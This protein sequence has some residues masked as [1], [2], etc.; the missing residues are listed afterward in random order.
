MQVQ[1]AG[2]AER[3][4]PVPPLHPP[5][6]PAAVAAHRAERHGHSTHS[7]AHRSEHPGCALC[8]C[9]SELCGS[10]AAWPALFLPV[11][12]RLCLLCLLLCL[13]PT[14]C[15]CL[16]AQLTLDASRL[17]SAWCAV[18]GAAMPAMPA[19]AVLCAA[20][21]AV[22]A[23]PSMPYAAMP[24]MSDAAVPAM[25]GVA[26]SVDY[27]NSSLLACASWSWVGCRQDSAGNAGVSW[28]WQG[29]CASTAAWM[30]SLWGGRCASTACRLMP[31]QPARL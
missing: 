26:M 30:S 6:R 2:R 17:L 12:V 11:L 15:S 19:A 8:K 24:A 4:I 22:P 21:P 29:G 31:W 5:V 13:L 18:P 16:I 25:P 23:M 7:I 20:L 28:G 3:N 9:D 1:P 27:T 10:G 14:Y